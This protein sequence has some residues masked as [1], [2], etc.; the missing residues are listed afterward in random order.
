MHRTV[1]YL[2]A[3]AA[4]TDL[5]CECVGEGSLR[6]RWRAAATRSGGDLAAIRLAWR[7]RTTDPTETWRR[8]FDVV[9]DPAAGFGGCEIE[10]PWARISPRGW[11]G[12]GVMG[13]REGEAG[14]GD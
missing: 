10:G 12:M 7:R 5:M 14:R 11:W 1:A 3:V 13:E 2:W 4:S 6:L 8:E 9:D